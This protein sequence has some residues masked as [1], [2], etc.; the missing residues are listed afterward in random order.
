MSRYVLPPRIC[1]SS[2]PCITV[3]PRSLWA[4]EMLSTNAGSHTTTHQT[5]TAADAAA[6]KPADT[7]QTQTKTNYYYS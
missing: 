2:A 3:Q 7:L 5:H 6:T 1:I 4:T